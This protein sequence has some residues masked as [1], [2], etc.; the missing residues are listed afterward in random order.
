VGPYI[1]KILLTRGRYGYED[2]MKNSSEI[3]REHLGGKRE[4][5]YRGRCE[6]Y[7]GKYI[8]DIMKNTSEI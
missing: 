2:I 4:K 6:K 5:I 7:F 1:S 8:E 3:Y